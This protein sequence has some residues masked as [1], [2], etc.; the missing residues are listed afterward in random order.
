MTKKTEL[1]DERQGIVHWL[2]DVGFGRLT[3]TVEAIGRAIS[4]LGTIN[5]RLKDDG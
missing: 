1:L 4:R 3:T 2:L 5:R